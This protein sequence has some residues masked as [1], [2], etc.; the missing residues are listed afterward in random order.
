MGT[1]KKASATR[2]VRIACYAKQMAVAVYE[3]L[4]ENIK[5]HDKLTS[6]RAG[7]RYA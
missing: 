4:A 2:A 5:S 1:K 3:I 7:W 6:R